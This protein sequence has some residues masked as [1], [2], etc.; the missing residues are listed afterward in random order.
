[1]GH[2]ELR[3]RR[4]LP[5]EKDLIKEWLDIRDRL[6]RPRLRAIPVTQA[7]PAAPSRPVRLVQLSTSS[8]RDRTLHQRSGKS[9]GHGKRQ[10]RRAEVAISVLDREAQEHW[11]RRPCHPMAWDL[12]DSRSCAFL[13]LALRHFDGFS[14]CAGKD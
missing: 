3:G 2:P 7:K 13:H 12:P 9:R 5:T 11:G 1:M 14:H 4:L 10:Q 6:V 8:D